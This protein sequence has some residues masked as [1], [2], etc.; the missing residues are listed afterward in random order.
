MER[1]STDM[2]HP[3]SLGVALLGS[4]MTATTPVHTAEYKGLVMTITHQGR[5]CRKGRSHHSSFV[6][7]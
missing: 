2:K 6:W 1:V 4:A 7:R 3:H 5:E